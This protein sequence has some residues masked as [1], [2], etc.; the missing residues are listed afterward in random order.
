LT[1]R[2]E[3]EAAPAEVPTAAASRERR[4]FLLAL[5]AV[6]LLFLAL[7]LAMGPPG[8]VPLV[9]G[10]VLVTAALL[11]VAIRL[12]YPSTRS[13]A[14]RLV[15][16]GGILATLGFGLLAWAAGGSH[17][18]Y[19]GFLPLLPLLVIVAIPD[20]PGVPI[21]VGLSGA[22][23]GLGIQA[24]EG[25]PPLQLAL[26]TLAFASTTL[27][28][29][30]G[31]LLWRRMRQRERDAELAGARARGALEDALWASR[32]SEA[33]YRAMAA[34]FPDGVIGLFDERLRLVLLD[35][36]R[37]MDG[38]AP[39]ALAGRTLPDVLPPEVARE[40]EPVC[41]RALRGE[42]GHCEIRHEG[43]DVIWSVHPVLDGQGGVMLGLLTA[44][45]V[46]ERR[47]L[48]TRLVISSR[49]AALG[50][51]VAGV[52]HEINNPLSGQMA[53]QVMAMEELRELR[54][55]VG[56]EG[57]PD[58]TALARRIDEALSLLDDAHS[59]GRRITRIVRDLSL[60]A[61]PD[62]QRSRVRL[63]EVV[64]SALRWLPDSVA[65]RASVRVERTA[66][67]EVNASPGQLGQVLA[68]LV[69][70]AALAIPPDRQGTITI[71]IGTTPHGAA[72]LD[73]ADD[74]AGIEPEVMGRIFDP[75]FTTREIGQGMGLGLPICH[76]IVAAH[77]GSLTARSTPGRGSTFRVELPPAA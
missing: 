15:V 70:N 42:A 66:A 40:V 52:A 50:T 56:A 26:W 47:S 49:L 65:A 38:S 25:A 31:A 77:A 19:L 43:R 39:G 59:A 35:G 17:G 54:D 22:A 27:Y 48:E 45:D 18:P 55:A 9:A 14:L 7:D 8:P 23:A 63:D 57:P 11:W 62:P 58:R 28:G 21:A 3:T 46:T 34:H 68:N 73:V 20:E 75:F 6:N 13:R 10:R 61:R 67:P 32:R 4:T 60:F 72:I 30:A 69:S 51:L 16:L 71:R 76:A 37:W 12:G 33:L 74:G 24:S 44:Q 1:T 2:G 29:W 36:T 53:S 64:E 5:G 41:L